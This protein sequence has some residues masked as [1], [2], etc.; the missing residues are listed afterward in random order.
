MPVRFNSA[1]PFFRFLSLLAL[2]CQTLI[3]DVETVDVLKPNF[4][5]D[6]RQRHSVA[7]EGEASVTVDGEECLKYV[8]DKESFDDASFD[9]AK[10]W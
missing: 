1:A 8:V 2:L 7:I 9:S 3:V 5:L 4:E 10:H 6:I